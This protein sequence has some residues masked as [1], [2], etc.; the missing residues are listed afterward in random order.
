VR[1]PV[2]A[3]EETATEAPQI[4]AAIAAGAHPQSAKEDKKAHKE[5]S[6][7]LAMHHP[8]CILWAMVN[9]LTLTL[10]VACV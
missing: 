9:V 8:S 6:C 7:A 10:S 1:L 3:Q 4:A 5:V 2:V